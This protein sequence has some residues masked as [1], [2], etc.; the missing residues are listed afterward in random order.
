VVTS[1]R[2]TLGSCSLYDIHLWKQYQAQGAVWYRRHVLAYS[3]GLRLFWTWAP[4]FWASRLWQDSAVCKPRMLPNAVW[5]KSQNGTV[6][7]YI[8]VYSRWHCLY[9]GVQALDQVSVL[10]VLVDYM[11]FP[12]HIGESIAF[13]WYGISSNRSSTYRLP[14]IGKP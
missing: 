12:L 10:D 5:T 9:I 8:F 1:K 6:Q 4:P 3:R 2:K 13:G 7:L 14:D 11:L